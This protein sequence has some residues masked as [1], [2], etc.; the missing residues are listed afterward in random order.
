VI[1]SPQRDM[2]EVGLLDAGE[3]TLV[4]A[5]A[6]THPGAAALSDGEQR[7]CYA[8]LD[9]RADLLAR[10]LRALDVRDGEYVGHADPCHPVMTDKSGSFQPGDEAAEMTA[11]ARQSSIDPGH[12]YRYS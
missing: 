1:E 5:R 4:A 7:T 8:E 6:R 2:A 10:G 12:K 9:A 11:G 3:R